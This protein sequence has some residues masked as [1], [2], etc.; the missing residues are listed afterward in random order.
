MTLAPPSAELCP[1]QGAE[2]RDIGRPL[3]FNGGLLG[4][5]DGVS[6]CMRCK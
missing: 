4:A 2:N 5:Y 3:H 6:G 1:G